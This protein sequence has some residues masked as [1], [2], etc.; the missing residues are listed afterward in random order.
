MA[1]I[2]V[3]SVKGGVGKTTLAV[4]LAWSAATTSCRRTLLWDLD[5]QGGSGYLLGL[6]PGK[7][8]QAAGILAREVDPVRAIRPTGI[9][10]L[11][12]LPADDSLRGLDSLFQRL[13][14][15]RRLAKLLEELSATYERI[16]LDC[17]P[18]LDETSAQILRA[19]DL[20]VVPLPPSPLA[21]RALET[22]RDELSRNYKRHPPLLP[23]LSMVDGRRRIHREVQAEFPDWPVIPMASQ[24]EQIAVRRAPIGTFAAS[25]EPARALERLW[26]GI[27]RRLI[28]M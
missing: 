7:R 17:A 6:E 8:L 16:V 13:G 25:S 10:R 28:A 18:G 27:E 5:P 23:V 11:D 9:D 26:A 12:L 3:Y 15:R 4:S 21:R 14:K 22:I 24:I 19:A 1:V 2:A 20:V